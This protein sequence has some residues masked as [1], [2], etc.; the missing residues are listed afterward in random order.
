MTAVKVY[1]Y[2]FSVGSFRFA[3]GLLLLCLILLLFPASAPAEDPV[4]KENDW[5][6]VDMSI[7]PSRGI[8]EDAAGR[9]ALIRQRGVLRVATEPYFPPHEYIDSSRSGQD[10]Y[11]GA[12]MDLARLIAQ[13]MG[14]ELEIIPMAFSDVLPAVSNGECDLAIAALSYTPSRAASV[15]LSRGYHYAG[16]DQGNG[17]LVREAEISLFPDAQSMENRVLAAQRGSLQESLGADH[18]PL[19]L[20]FRRL[21]GMDDIYAALQSGSVDA[22]VVEIENTEAWLSAHPDS[23]LALLPGICYALSPEEDGNRVAA[24]KGE[25]QL[26]AFVNGVIEEVLASGQYEA[27]FDEHSRVSAE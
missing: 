25:L 17:I 19:Y 4:L 2:F 23:G 6:Y 1:P 14:V 7:D 26:T 5:N 27:W 20:E 22:A 10:Q 15:E 18:V 9:L 3:C 13:R 12:D 16:E 21:P 8:P 11:V 24:R